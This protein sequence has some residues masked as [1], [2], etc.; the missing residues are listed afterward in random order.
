MHSTHMC[1]H[2]K[3]CSCAGKLNIIDDTYYTLVRLLD[4]PGS[5]DPLVRFEITGGFSHIVV[6]D[7]FY[8][9]YTVFLPLSS[10]K[11]SLLELSFEAT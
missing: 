2:L 11:S 3:V 7:I 10:I 5:W 4:P 6:N 8:G 9:K 1:K